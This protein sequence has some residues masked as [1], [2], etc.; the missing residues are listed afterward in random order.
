MRGGPSTA[1]NPATVLIFGTGFIGEQVARMATANGHSVL[2]TTRSMEREARL[3]SRRSAL[4]SRMVM[5]SR[6]VAREMRRR[7]WA[8][9]LC[10]CGSTVQLCTHGWC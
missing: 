8:W 5:F 9:K 7:W 3:A 4:V 6:W 2:G 10:Y 1:Q